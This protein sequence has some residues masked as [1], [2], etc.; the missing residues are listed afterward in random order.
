MAQILVIEDS[1]Y[2]RRKIRRALAMEG[3][4]LLEAVNGYE[5]L[6]MIAANTPDCILVDLLMPEMD[7]LAV[8]QSLHSQGTN[9]PV[10]VLTA[11]IQDGTRQR[12]MELG[13]AA[14]ISKPL[15]EDELVNAIRQVIGDR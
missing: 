2:Q 12:C 14:F 3:Y 4:E 9:I 15:Q 1:A 13:A 10:I 6:E 7:G 8:L 5:G 11:D